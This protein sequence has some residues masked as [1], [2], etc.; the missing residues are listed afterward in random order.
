[1]PCVCQPQMLPLYSTHIWVQ[2]VLNR[3]SEGGVLGLVSIRTAGFH[4]QSLNSTSIHTFRSVLEHVSICE[5]RHI[6]FELLPAC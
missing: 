2:N 1:M 6:Q 4:W 3:V 5:D